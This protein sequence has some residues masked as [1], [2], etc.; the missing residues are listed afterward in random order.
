MSSKNDSNTLKSVAGV[1][2]DIFQTL[3]ADDKVFLSTL[4]RMGVDLETLY[5]KAS[6]GVN[7]NAR[8]LSSP[9]TS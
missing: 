2:H 8:R 9:G 1:P 6:Y 3:P 7:D 4:D 5:K